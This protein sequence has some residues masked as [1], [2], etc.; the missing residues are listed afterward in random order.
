M[1]KKLVCFGLILSLCLGML[2]IPVGAWDEGQQDG[3]TVLFIPLDDRPISYDRTVLMAQSLEI[4][5]LVP[6][7]D[8]FSTK[9]DGQI[10]NQNGTQYG[11]RGRLLQY[12]MDYADEADVLILSLDQL[13]SGGLMNSRCVEEMTPVVMPDGSTMTEYEVL[14]YLGNLAEE[15]E[16][17]LIDSVLRFANSGEYGGYSAADGKVTRSYGRVSRPVLAEQ[18]LTVENV[19]ATNLLAENGEPA[20][21]QAGFSA[22]DLTRLTGDDGAD[23]TWQVQEGSLLDRYLSIRERKLRLV[24]Y[25]LRTFQGKSQ[26]HFILGVDDSSGGNTIHTNEIAYYETLMEGDWQIFSAMDGLMQTALAQVYLNWIGAD[27]VNV[28]LSYF[29]GSPEQVGDYNYIKVEDMVEDTIHYHYGSMVTEEPDIAVLVYCTTSDETLA[30]TEIQRLV[31]QINENAENHLPTMLLDLSK[32]ECYLMRQKLVEE[33]DLGYLLAYNGNAE[34]TVQI[35]LMLSQGIARYVQLKQAGTISQEAQEKYL[36]NLMWCYVDEYYRTTG[37][38]DVMSRYLAN[39]GYISNMGTLSD[40]L[41][42]EI[43]AKLTVHVRNAA[44]P[45]IENIQNGGFI[46]NLRPYEVSNVT[47]MEIVSCVYPWLRQFEFGC[48]INAQV[49]QE[50]MPFTDVKESRFYYEPLRW[51]LRQNMVQGMTGNT[52][53]PGTSCDR[54]MVVT[55]LWRMAGEPE[56]EGQNPFTDVLEGRYYYKAVLWAAENGIVQGMTDH[57][58]EPDTLCNRAM[59]VTLLWRMTG[60]PEQMQSRFRDVSSGRYYSTAVYWAQES[61]VTEGMTERDFEPKG[62]CLREQIVTFLYRFAC[63]DC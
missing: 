12:V 2:C 10:T 22:A 60:E 58:F 41:E 48:I 9:L 28:E 19:L 59:V 47:N 15:K 42:R 37:E 36:E 40:D 50:E 44:V 24:D 5:L 43:H 34:A 8:W 18:D 33:I 39:L 27:G 17:Y 29:G 55:L 56:P 61:R 49:E 32:N 23:G 21:M 45:L 7:E 46:S 35:N 13:L 38:R 6:E 4:Q 14:D 62:V 52:F 11:D 16:V 1:K 26:A 30:E 53:E 25:A 51:A 3:L 57:T 20:Y 63:L 31:D 54:A